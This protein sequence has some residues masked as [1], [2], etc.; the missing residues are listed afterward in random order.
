[1]FRWLFKIIFFLA[2]AGLVYGFFLLYQ[3]KTPEEKKSLQESVG[4]VARRTGDLV[5]EAGS[6]TIKKVKEISSEPRE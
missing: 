1:M 3:E 4:R 5:R 2:L 6:K